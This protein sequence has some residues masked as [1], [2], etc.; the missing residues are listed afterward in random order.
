[1]PLA[2]PTARR[3]PRRRAAS[4]PGAP[5]PPAASSRRRPATR[6]APLPPPRARERE[7]S[8]VPLQTHCTA[9]RRPPPAAL[10]R[11]AA[12]YRITLGQPTADN[13]ALVSGILAVL[14]VNVVVGTF[15]FVA[16]RE[17]DPGP[18]ED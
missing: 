16:F 10:A 13:R 12:L 15:I 14:A 2:R 7:R 17:A 3:R 6:S 4:K 1:L 18:K 8:A 9:R 11:P 5:S